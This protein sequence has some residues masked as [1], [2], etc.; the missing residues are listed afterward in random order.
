[1]NKL[2]VFF[3]NLKNLLIASTKSVPV[4]RRF[5][6]TFL[7]WD[8]SLHSF[9]ANSFHNNPC[10]LTNTKLR[11]LHCR[12][13][14]P[15][16]GKLHKVLERASHETNKKIIDNLMKY[17]K[18]C[19]KHGKSPSN[20]KFALKED[21][22]FNYSIFVDIM[23]INGDPILHVVNEATKFQA[24]RWL[25]NMSAKHTWD[26]L[27]LCWTDVYIGSSDFITHDAGT[28]FV[29][30]EFCHYATSKALTTRSVQVEA[31]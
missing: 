7:L 22:N 9:I 31:Y 25:N 20:F 27:Q 5:G 4:V 23:Y 30:K 12:F 28:N 2:N 8:E 17:C 15:S 24:A 29:S 13:K 16:A 14:H 19:Q 18:H 21:G 10:F 6:H 1:M 26:T 3:N 11:Q